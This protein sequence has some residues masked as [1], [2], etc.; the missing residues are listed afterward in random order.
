MYVSENTEVE[1]YR[2]T[3]TEWV[4]H[5]IMALNNFLNKYGLYTLYPAY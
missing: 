5:K 1:P 4:V 2:A 3:G